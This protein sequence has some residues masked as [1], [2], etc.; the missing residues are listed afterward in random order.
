MSTLFAS[1]ARAGRAGRRALALAVPLLAAGALAAGCGAAQSSSARASSARASS[2]PGTP[3]RATVPAAPAK[4]ATPVP[5]ISGGQVAAGAVACVGWP[6]GGTSASLP[7]SFVPV[8]VERCVNG[9]QMISGKGL[10]TT[11]TLQ[12][13]TGDLTG[14]INALRQPPAAHRPG[15]VCPAVAVI[16]PQVV[17]IS[18]SGQKL[19][20]R[21]P[22][23]GC[24]L[25][26]SQV[27]TALGALRWQT[28][29]VRLIAKVSGATEPTVSG[30]APHSPQALGAAQPG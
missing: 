12:R 13:S 14:L 20:P 5:T 21:L 9:A 8:S 25:T 28:V 3:G 7:V 30:T 18:A 27:L 24:G 29:S 23:S 2:A 6:T 16:P 10:W 17:L 4:S 22:D 19:F 26:S 1:T 11:A 15:T